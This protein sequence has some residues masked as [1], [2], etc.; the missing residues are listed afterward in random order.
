MCTAIATIIYS[1]SC[2]VAIISQQPIMSLLWATRGATAAADNRRERGE[3]SRTG[4]WL[5]WIAE[6]RRQPRAATAR[7][8]LTERLRLGGRE[9]RCGGWIGGA[10]PIVEFEVVEAF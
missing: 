7:M 8:I 3:Y 10:V 1:S 9:R 6:G 5:P 2:M 4:R